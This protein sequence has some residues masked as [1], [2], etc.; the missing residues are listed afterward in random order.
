MKHQL[1]SDALRPF[2]MNLQLFAEPAQ[3]GETGGDGAGETGG[4]G[5]TGGDKGG[6]ERRFTQ[7]ELDALLER[8]LARER[9]AAKKALDEAVDKA[10]QEGEERARMSEQERARADAERATQAQRDREA[11][12]NAR[13]SEITRRELRAEAVDTLQQR[14]LPRELA[15]L[16]DYSSAEARDKSLETLEKTYRASVQA[17]IDARIRQSGGAPDQGGSGGN[18]DTS[19][20]SDAEYY[21]QLSRKKS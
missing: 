21:A 16:L 2:T 7:A 3:T 8:R 11:A 15:D 14:Q 1:I 10:R 9:Q 5:E 4:T 20:L 19:K 18:V 6:E 17:G 13:E 12:L